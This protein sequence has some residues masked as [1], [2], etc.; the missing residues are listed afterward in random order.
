M[1]FAGNQIVYS[2]ELERLLKQDDSPC[3]ARHEA[4]CI[5]PQSRGSEGFIPSWAAISRYLRHAAKQR[6]PDR[7]R[8]GVS[9]A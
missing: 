8:S 5:A 3:D 1:P 9:A 7:Y 2:N 4:H 6:S